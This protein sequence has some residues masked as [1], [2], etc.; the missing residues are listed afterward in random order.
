M[1][2]LTW[3]YVRGPLW[4]KILLFS[5]LNKFLF[6]VSCLNVCKSTYWPYSWAIFCILAISTVIVNRYFVYG[7]Q[8]NTLFTF[9]YL[10]HKLFLSQHYFLHVISIFNVLNILLQHYITHICP[11]YREKKRVITETFWAVPWQNQQNGF[12]TSMDPEQPA[13][14]RSL[15]RNHA[16]C[17]PT[18]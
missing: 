8:K 6:L 13:H 5:Y 2:I 17:L 18:L 1:I 9:C 7:S 15:I 14:Q 4:L 3:Y 10:Y 12:A 16:V 11:F